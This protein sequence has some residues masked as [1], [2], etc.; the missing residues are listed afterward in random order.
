MTGPWLIAFVLQWIVL[1]VLMLLMAGVLRHLS[2]LQTYSIDD[3]PPITRFKLQ[4]RIEDFALPNIHGQL[5]SSKSFLEQ[6]RNV[7]LFFVSTT[8]SPCRAV[9]QHI[10]NLAAR[11]GGLQVYGWS[12]IFVC[13]GESVASEEMLKDLPLSDIQVLIDPGRSVYQQYGIRGVPVVLALDVKGRLQ[14]QTVSPDSEWLDKMLGISV[15][16]RVQKPSAD[17]MQIS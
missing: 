4:E 6:N 9:V 15:S 10:K 13:Y 2:S 12:F 11:E 16:N 17:Y 14:N 7:L 5:I 8:C 1:G 3:S